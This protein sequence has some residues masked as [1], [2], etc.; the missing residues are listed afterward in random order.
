MGRIG[1][2]G[3]TFNPPHIGHMAAAAQAVDA[4]KLD[5]LLLI[6][7]SIAPHKAMPEVSAN[8]AQRLEM[9]QLASRDMDKVE[10][11]DIE[12]TRPGKSYSYETVLQLKKMYPHEELV[13][14]VGTDMFLSFH[15]WMHPEIILENAVI[16][17]LYRGEPGELAT[18]REKKE[19]MEK[20]GA[21]IEL[22]N[23]DVL[24]MSSTDLRKMLIFRCADRLLPLGVGDY[25]R[26]N[27]LY[28]TKENYR[29]LSM[30]Q[31]EKAVTGLLKEDRVDHVLGCRDTAVALAKH[32]GAD[33]TDAARAG[34][35]H[36]ITKALPGFAQLTLCREYGTIPDDFS[37]KN[38]KV[39]HALTG[40][41]V[42]QRIF[43]ENDRVTQA[44]CAHT[45][46]K[47]YMN[48]LDKII[49]VA[50]Y[51][52]P[53]RKFPG[54]DKLRQLAY[55]DLDAAVVLGLTM[56]VD[57]LTRQGREV[58]PVSKETLAWLNHESEK[59]K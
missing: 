44:I 45:T 11:S 13:L 6:P 14:I 1:I 29:G 42:A 51:M 53:N 24:Q 25:I 23:N 10:V 37:K 31:L 57:L 58:S 33:E 55:T 19:Q 20:Q 8:P 15:T 48:L 17:V 36:D 34:L 2:Y 39:L 3:G 4:L 22:V 30:A 28:G 7:A 18:V 16:G 43:G 27:G 9:V 5:R 50:D 38:P 59:E 26:D 40:S 52:E 35:L 46:G 56:S 49:Y 12:L 54:V 47:P 32:W 21:R 41:L